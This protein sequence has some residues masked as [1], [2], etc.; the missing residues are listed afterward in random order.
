MFGIELTELL[1]FGKQVGIAL[2][3]AAALWGFVFSRKD[4]HCSTDKPCVIYDWIAVRLLPLFVSGV[5]IG[6]LFYFG[7]L[8]T[9]PASAHEGIS[10]VPTNPEVVRS[11]EILTP[12][13]LL[14]L[15][16]TVVMLFAPGK[17]SNTFAESIT[18]FYVGTFLVSF[19]I[20]SFPGWRGI[21]D[22]QQIFYIGHG[23][24]SIF[25][26]GSVIVLDYLFLLSKRAHILK[27]HIFAVFPTIS[28]AVWFGLA[29]DFA[30]TLFI[31]GG[32]VPTT[33]M[34]FMQTV[35]GILII[36]GVLLSGPLVRKMLAAIK[37]DG[38]GL[39]KTWETIAGLAGVI[40]ITS[41][42]TITFVDSFEHLSLSYLEYVGLY[43]AFIIL[44]YAGH[45]VVEWYQHC[46][47]A[48]EFVH[49]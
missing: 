31:I 30:S 42:T 47:Q 25:T 28:A 18:Y 26:L 40:S 8:V 2:A 23:F 49:N 21:F 39:S 15:V 20:T 5:G 41:W 22:S 4:F 32:F 10:Y 34:L 3:G 16:A 43:L 37:P 46:K 29:F 35:I 19:F 9:L 38:D 27:E 44:A 7:L 48:P 13:F 36:N 14:L 1:L 33:K 11:F 12:L 6:S 17:K 45:K 24:H